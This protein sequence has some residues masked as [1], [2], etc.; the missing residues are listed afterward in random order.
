ML[1]LAAEYLDAAEAKRAAENRV[2]AIQAEILDK[3]GENE[4]AMVEGFTV[5][6]PTIS[7]QPDKEIT[8]DMVGTIIKGKRSHRRFYIKEL[9]A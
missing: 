4:F 1:H 6:V 5:K 3:V 9:A 8:A 2:E 7:G